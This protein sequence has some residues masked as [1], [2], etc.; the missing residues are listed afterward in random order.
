MSLLYR[1]DLNF[2]PCLHTAG[3][4]QRRQVDEEEEEAQFKAKPLNKTILEAPVGPCVSYSWRD[5][6]VYDYNCLQGPCLARWEWCSS[7]HSSSEC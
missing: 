2:I 7:R 5:I 3:E 1:R 4:R 6:V